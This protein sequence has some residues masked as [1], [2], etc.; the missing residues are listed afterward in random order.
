MDFGLLGIR[1][2]YVQLL[3]APDLNQGQEIAK[4]LCTGGFV[5]EMGKK[6]KNVLQ[7]SAQVQFD[8]NF[9]ENHLESIF[10][11]ILQI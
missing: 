1:G 11:E 7:M 10:H 3:V 9:F 5:K 4:E 6:V 2:A 8:Y